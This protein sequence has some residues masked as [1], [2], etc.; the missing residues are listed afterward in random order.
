ML[1]HSG[2]STPEELIKQRIAYHIKNENVHHPYSDE[3]LR[4]LLLKEEIEI[5]RRTITKYRE[6]MHILST[7]YR[8][9]R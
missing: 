8:R 1:N 5:S 4:K 2:T 9:V 6:S 3:Q 7:T